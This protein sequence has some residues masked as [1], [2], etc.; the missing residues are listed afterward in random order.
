MKKSIV[1]FVF[2]F[3][4]ALGYSQSQRLVLLEH[5]TQASCGPCATYNPAIQALLLA[6]PD[7]ITYINYHTSWP[8]VDVMYNHNPIDAGARTSY[9]GVSSV[10]NSVLNGNAYNGHPSGWNINTV[11]T[12]YAVP[13]PMEINI[14]QELSP[15][16]DTIYAT[17]IVKATADIPGQPSAY[18]S[19]IEKFIQFNTAP[20]SNGEKDFYNVMK[21]LLPEKTGISLPSDMQIGE[22]V[23]IQTSWPLANVYDVD[24]LSLIGFVQN[25]LNKEIYQAANVT[26]GDFT[27][28][29]NNDVELMMFTNLS[30]RM[31]KPSISPILRIRNNGNESLT[32]LQIQYRINNEELHTF[33]WSG[34]LPLLSTGEIALPA[35]DYELLAE[36]NI[37]AFVTQVNQGAD[38]YTINDTINQSFEAALQASKNI[39]VKVRTDN[40]PE[41]T[42]WEIKN[43]LGEVVASGGPYAQSGTVFNTDVVLE[44]DD[45]YEF[46]MYDAGGN[47]LCCTNGTGFYKLTSGSTTLAQGTTFEYLQTAQFE[48]NTVGVNFPDAVTDFEVYPNPSS[49]QLFVEFT[50]ERNRTVSVGIFNQLGQSVYSNEI[51]SPSDVTQ[52]LNINTS[53]WPVGIYM[54]RMDN[55]SGI[56]SSKVS[57]S[58]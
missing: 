37:Q 6:N 48:V 26:E 3:S 25:T 30:D 53:N 14:Y 12:L 29:Y 51:L 57:V 23:I 55:G 54:I 41:Q 39:L 31:C 49:S 45:C 10:P 40:S 36:N 38:E 16:N 28:L 4:I 33:D 8:G 50:P 9:Y 17:M 11:N 43:S 18:I 44:N 7:K 27:A 35:L 52:K 32:N 15:G 24:Q 58:R 47:G 1:L 22:Y 2:L 46:F 5:F 20:G 19:V 13:S 42:T 21:K 34:N 56:S